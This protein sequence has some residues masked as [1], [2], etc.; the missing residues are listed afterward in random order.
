MPANTPDLAPLSN[1]SP[2]AA[3]QLSSGLALAGLTAASF[4]LSGPL[5][6]RLIAAGWS[7]TAAVVARIALAAALLI[8][9][10]LRLLHGR[11]DEL[12]RYGVDIV[13]YG[14][15]AVAGTQLA[16][17][18]AVSRL[19][20]ATALLVE[21][22]APVVVLG[23]FWAARGQRPSGRTMVGGAL[24]IAGLVPVLGVGAT[25]DDGL[26]PVGIGCALL[27]MC[28]LAYYFVVSS[29]DKPGLPPM[30][31]AC[32]GLV[33][34]SLTLALVAGVG[35]LPLATS[36]TSPVYAGTALP[37]W[38][39][40]TLLGV[41]TAALAYST[42][43]AAARRLGGRLA[44][45]VALSEVVLAALFAALLLGQQPSWGQVVGG[46]II[47]GGIVLVK[48]GETPAH[49]DA[50]PGIGTRDDS[51]VVPPDTGTDLPV[52]S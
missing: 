37:W 9:P 47:L 46:T 14:M 41:V 16:Y 7:P 20:V 10:A 11:W 27:A 38:L 33:V 32:G 31:L 17:F 49:H 45:F 21:F 18:V 2:G 6:T 48:L 29:A 39:A 1:A 25:G 36:T 22:L 42:G 52:G 26:D 40:V 50:G 44:S 23:W 34:G 15:V 19:P 28:G 4:A 24:A 30:V 3:G 51:A 35:V 12:R 43:I 13:A 5:A 8:A